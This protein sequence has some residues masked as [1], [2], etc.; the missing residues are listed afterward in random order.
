MNLGLLKAQFVRDTN[1]SNACNKYEQNPLRMKE[2]ITNEHTNRLTGKV[3]TIGLLPTVVGGAL[4]VVC[5]TKRACHQHN[6][7]FFFFHQV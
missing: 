4:P 2:I 1:E 5:I 3:N 6:L 7:L